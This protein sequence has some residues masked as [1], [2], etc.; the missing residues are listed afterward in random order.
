MVTEKFENKI[1]LFYRCFHCAVCTIF[2]MIITQ[3]HEQKFPMLQL[4][5]A[6]Y[7]SNNQIQIQKSHLMKLNS[8]K[9]PEMNF[10]LDYT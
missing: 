2:E 7:Y 3:I 8:L 1:S 6:L 4:W 5:L 9:V 10:I